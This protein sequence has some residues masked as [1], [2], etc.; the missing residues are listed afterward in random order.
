MRCL[1]FQIQYITLKSQRL[2]LAK[3]ELRWGKKKEQ[4]QNV[5]IFLLKSPNNTEERDIVL[6]AEIGSDGW[7]GVAIQGL[8]RK[9]FCFD[10]VSLERFETK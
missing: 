1:Y 9:P 4:R 3:N 8:E 2:K 6:W 7:N 5:K 10:N